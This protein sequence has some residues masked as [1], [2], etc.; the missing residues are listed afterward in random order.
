MEPDEATDNGTHGSTP[1]QLG[2]Y[3]R[4]IHEYYRYDLDDDG[5][6]QKIV[7]NPNP[8]A[9]EVYVN[10]YRRPVASRY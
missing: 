1:R 5:I 6:V 8:N 9:E 2:W 10:L 7:D 3:R 4:E